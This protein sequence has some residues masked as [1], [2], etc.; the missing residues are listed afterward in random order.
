VAIAEL[1]AMDAGWQP[2]VLSGAVPLALPRRAYRWDDPPLDMQVM[3][4]FHDDQ[5]VV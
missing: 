4:S 3:P 5:T 2:Q 1:D